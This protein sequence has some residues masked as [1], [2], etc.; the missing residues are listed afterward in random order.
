MV[1]SSE[2]SVYWNQY[3]YQFKPLPMVCFSLS[4]A[5]FI[6]VVANSDAPDILFRLALLP[7]TGNA[8]EEAMTSPPWLT[9]NQQ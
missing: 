3:Q 2:Q 9:V 7:H 1:E 4:C 5:P 6:A 8:I